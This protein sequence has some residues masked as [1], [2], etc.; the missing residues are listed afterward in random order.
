V[1][2]IYG[3]IMD[4]RRF[5]RLLVGALT[6]GKSLLGNTGGE[7]TPLPQWQRQ[8]LEGGPDAGEPIRGEIVDGPD[9]Y[10]PDWWEVACEPN[11]GYLESVP[12]FDFVQEPMTF[13][14]VNRY[15]GPSVIDATDQDGPVKLTGE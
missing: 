10:M 13:D 9:Y 1:K 11:T 7:L 12:V 2:P 3:P 6:V 4:R 8:K 15:A 5:T 14:P